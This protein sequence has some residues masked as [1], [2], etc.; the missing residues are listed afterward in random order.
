MYHHQMYWLWVNEFWVYD[1]DI[2]EKF[3]THL[4]YVRRVSIKTAVCQRLSH[5]CFDALIRA[6]V[7]A[8]NGWG[9]L[10]CN[11]P[12]AERYRLAGVVNIGSSIDP[13]QWLTS[14]EVSISSPHEGAQPPYFLWDRE[15]K[16]TIKSSSLHERPLYSIVSHTWGRWRTPAEPIRIDGVPWPIPQ[17]TKFDVANLPNLLELPK[18]KTR[19]VWIDLLCI[20]QA[21]TND[22]L[23]A[24]R[25]IEIGRQAEIFLGAYRPYAWLSDID[26]WTGLR[27]TCIWIGLNFL[28]YSGRG[29][30]G[31]EDLIKEFTDPAMES[32]Q[33][34]KPWDYSSRPAPHELEPI[35]WF[36]SLWTLQEVSI[37]PDMVLLDRNLVPFTL[38]NSWIITFDSL[39]ALVNGYGN[40]SAWQEGIAP[41]K[42]APDLPPIFDRRFLYKAFENLPAGA[43]GPSDYVAESYRTYTAGAAHTWRWKD[44]QLRNPSITVN[45]EVDIDARYLSDGRPS[46]PKGPSELICLLRLTGLDQIHSITRLDILWNAN[47]RYCK[48]S[49]AEAIMS[50][51]GVTDWYHDRLNTGRLHETNREDLVL[52]KYPQVFLEEA[53]RKLGASFFSTNPRF[54]DLMKPL[55]IIRHDDGTFQ[56]VRVVDGKGTLLPVVSEPKYLVYQR[57]FDM[58]SGVCDHPSLQTWHLLPDGSF[59]LAEV[60]I[61]ATSADPEREPI[62]VELLDA[63]RPGGGISP[64]RSDQLKDVDLR[65]YLQSFMPKEY[66]VAV[67]IYSGPEVMSGLILLERQLVFNVKPKSRQF[68]KVGIFMFHRAWPVPP[69]Q[70][71]DWRVL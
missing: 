34:V 2:N 22:R 38:V 40:T 66:K 43:E 63:P 33:L 10:D 53:I 15:Q 5:S 44:E 56:E 52:D 29:M 55:C 58:P 30:A 47:S 3:L 6:Q 9:Y 17:N 45:P 67:S 4:I 7:R 48:R 64:G 26:D 11:E 68:V 31:A 61:V 39:V 28:M 41:D 27:N 70:K 25:D 18:F 71:V 57:V 23:L 35:G 32:T 51:V 19:Y 42:L 1:E 14:E 12:P 16:A 54:F 24:I 60:G 21:T 46:V 8:I 62:V 36:S 49:R 37:R 65:K 50:V 59:Q 69:S 20:P 13:C